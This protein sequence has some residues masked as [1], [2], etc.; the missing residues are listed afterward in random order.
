MP[1]FLYTDALLKRFGTMYASIPSTMCDVDGVSTGG[2]PFR[3]LAGVGLFGLRPLNLVSPQFFPS[4]SGCY[5][6]PLLPRSD[7]THPQS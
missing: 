7:Y 3:G 2:G 6:F 5:R 1:L 4:R